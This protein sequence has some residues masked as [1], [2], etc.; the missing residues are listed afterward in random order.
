MSDIQALRLRPE[1]CVLVVVDVQERLMAAMPEK[2]RPQVIGRI[3]ALIEA[4]KRLGF[5]AIVTEQYPKGLGATL[6]EVASALPQGTAPLPKMSFSC[7]GAEGFMER[8]RSL[9]RTKVLLT[10]AETHVC[11]YQ[12]ALDLMENG[13]I[14]HAVADALCSRSKL[15]WRTGLAALE[16]AGAVPTTAEQALFDLLRVAG[17]E[18]FK[19]LSRLIR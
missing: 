17:T 16:R 8:L 13:F 1:E 10:G 19:A 7:C 4:G 6:G 15:N 3:Q 9:G 2:V 11:C 12:T 14:V 18:D 5:P